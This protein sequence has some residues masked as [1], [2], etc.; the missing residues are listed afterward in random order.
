MR[1]EIYAHHGYTFTSADLKAH[2]AK[3]SWYKPLGDNSKI[4]LSQLEQ[5]NVDLIKA[6][7]DKKEE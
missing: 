2:F 7:E 6:E 5:L 3:M 4:K 1:N